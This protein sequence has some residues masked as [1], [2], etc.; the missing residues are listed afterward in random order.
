MSATKEQIDKAKNDAKNAL[1]SDIPNARAVQD[2]IIL[3]DALIAQAEGK[4]V[5]E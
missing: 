4:E 2:C 1:P 5:G 3:Y